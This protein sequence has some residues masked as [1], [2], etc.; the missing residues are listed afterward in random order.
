[1]QSL[2]PPLKTVTHL[3]ACHVWLWIW[4]AVLVSDSF[5]NSFLR[6]WIYLPAIYV[7]IH[8]L[9]PKLDRYLIRPLHNSLLPHNAWSY[10]ALLLFPTRP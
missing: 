3:A 9:Y 8:R 5:M 10:S 1:M 4:L 2:L 6:H 7:L